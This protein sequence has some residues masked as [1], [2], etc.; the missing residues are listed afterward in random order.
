LKSALKLRESDSKIKEER[1]NKEK[2]KPSALNQ[3]FVGHTHN[4][5][6]EG[7]PR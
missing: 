5:G 7:S 6:M 4:L 1:E 2:K 3:R